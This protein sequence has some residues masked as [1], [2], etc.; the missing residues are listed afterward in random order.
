MGLKHILVGVVGMHRETD[1]L[2]PRIFPVFPEMIKLQFGKEYNVL[3]CIL[4]L[5]YSDC[6]LIM[7]EKYMVTPNFLFGFQWRFL[8]SAFVHKLL[9]ITLV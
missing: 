4:K 6:C 8:R 2:Y 7:F 9:K 5:F 3:L 1:Y